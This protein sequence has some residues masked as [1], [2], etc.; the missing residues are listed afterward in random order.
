M[1]LSLT[2]LSELYSLAYPEIIPTSVDESDTDTTTDS[3]F[4]SS[5]R[6]LEDLERKQAR[7]QAFMTHHGLEHCLD[8]IQKSASN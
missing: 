5:D 6:E 8:R 1:T 7:L 4:A 2:L 3:S